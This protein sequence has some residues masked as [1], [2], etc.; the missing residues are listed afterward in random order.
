MAL[1]MAGAP[2][3]KVVEDVLIQ[4]SV[5]MAAPPVEPVARN[6]EVARQFHLALDQNA[7]APIAPASASGGSEAALKLEGE[8][9]DLKAAGLK[10]KA[11]AIQLK[12]QR[13]QNRA[14]QG[15]GET[16]EGDILDLS[17]EKDL[18]LAE[19]KLC[20]MN[21]QRVRDSLEQRVATKDQQTRSESQLNQV[22]E[23]L[24]VDQA[25]AVEDAKRQAVAA[26][27]THEQ[28]EVARAEAAKAARAATPAKIQMRAPGIKIERRALAAMASAAGE[29]AAPKA[30]PVPDDDM[31]HLPEAELK[32]LLIT[33]KEMEELQEQLDSVEKEAKPRNDEGRLEK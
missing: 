8:Y 7:P 13:A 17:A 9:W 32:R 14:A 11:E 10:K 12:V 27:P 28:V 31:A 26:E 1:S 21:A 16:D 15:V 33:A 2:P 5:P 18:T 29:M 23:K 30:E 19:V 22:I 24:A 6:F 25:A 3:V 20:E 4:S